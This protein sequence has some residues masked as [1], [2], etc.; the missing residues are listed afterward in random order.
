MSSA[1]RASDADVKPTRSANSTETSRRSAVGCAAAA[2]AVAG[3]AAAAERRAALAAELLAAVE[4]GAARGAG[5]GERG[6]AFGA[7]LPPRGVLGAAAA[8]RSRTAPPPRRSAAARS[9]HGVASSRSKSLARLGEQRLGLVAAARSSACSSCVTREPEG[10]A[11]A[12]GSAPPPPR[13]PLGRRLAAR[14]ARGSASP[15]R[16][17]TDDRAPAASASTCDEQLLRLRPGRRGRA[18][19]RAASTKRLLDG[20]LR[21]CRA[22]SRRPRCTAAGGERLRGAPLGAEQRRPRAAGSG[23]APG[24]RPTLEPAK[25]D[26]QRGAPRQLATVEADLVSR[27]QQAQR[28]AAGRLLLGNLLGQPRAPRPSAR[29]WT[30]R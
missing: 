8:R 16:R 23:P 27:L 7:E 19:P 21:R 3:A 25:S 29:A 15:A 18:R 30:G 20:L 26:E 6:A 4:G 1:S 14:G 11:R 22:S 24:R 13:S 5:G 10:H 9:S 12:R 17:G 2:G 28:D